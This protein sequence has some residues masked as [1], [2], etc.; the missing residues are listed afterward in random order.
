MGES[1]RRGDRRIPGDRL[2]NALRATAGEVA[3]SRPRQPSSSPTPETMDTV[4]LL[5]RLAEWLPDLC[6]RVMLGKV[7]RD[8]WVLLA[9]ALRAASEAAAGEVGAPLIIDPES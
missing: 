2:A 7:G 3:K 1:E 6:P 4:A 9:N 8:E 5:H